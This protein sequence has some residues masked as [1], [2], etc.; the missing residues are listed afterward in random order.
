MSPSRS[1]LSYPLSLETPRGNPTARAVTS[2]PIAS[3][4]AQ[5]VRRADPNPR[6]ALLDPDRSALVM[7][8]EPSR[9]L[10][11]P[12]LAPDR[13]CYPTDVIAVTAL[14]LFRAILTRMSRID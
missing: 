4:V 3:R 10:S 9:A 2:T 12:M 13:A 8:S 6:P 7:M 1:Q 5:R 11:L 14:A